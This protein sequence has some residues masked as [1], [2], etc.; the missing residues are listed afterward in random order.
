MTV[1]LDRHY[2]VELHAS[3]ERVSQI[4]R[5]VAAHLRYWKLD[6]HVAP[7][8]QGI[9]ELLT[10][11]HRHV[12]DD[13]RCIVELRWTGRHLTTSVEDN[14]PR[15]P[16]LLT[17]GGGGLARVAAVSDSWGTCATAEGKVIWFTRSVEAPQSVPRV[18][19]IPLTLV[20]AAQRHPGPDRE[21]LPVLAPFPAREPAAALV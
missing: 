19:T 10:N 1:P 12:G 7:V 3:A 16:R 20:G 5:I 8:S 17:A 6:L 18:P 13:N 14:G 9:D 2:E 4:R 21:F 15:M 11:V